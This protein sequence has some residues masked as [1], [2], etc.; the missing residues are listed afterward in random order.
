MGKIHFKVALRNLMGNK[1]SSFINIGGLAVGMAVALLIGL[2]IYDELSFNKGHSNYAR[3]GQ[4]KVHNGDGTYSS[5]PA[6]L[7][8]ELHS[9]FAGDFKNV[10]LSSNTESHII[11]A[12][13]QAGT[14]KKLTRRG[15]YMQPEGPGMFTLKMAAGTRD[16]LQNPH[17]VLLSRSLAKQLFGDED[18]VGRVANI[19]NKSAV[20]VTGVYEDLPDN[21]F[22]KEVAFVAP[23]DLYV[24]SNDF[25]RESLGDWKENAY[26]IYV[27]LQPGKDFDRVSGEIKD[28]KIPHISKE[29][30]GL[31]K[32]AFF[33]Q[34][35]SRWHLYSKYENRVTVTSEELKFV[36]FYGIIGGFVLLLAC[37]NFMNLSTARSE[38]RAKEVGIRKAIGSLRSQLIGQFF[39]E[40]LLVSVCSFL[41][42][43]GLVRLALPWFNGIAGKTL[44]IP[45][46]NPFFWFTGIA[47]ISFTGLLAGSY[48]AFY[49]SSFKAVK[50]LKGTFRLGRLAAM[51]RKMLVVLQ[52]TV[53]IALIIA[54]IVV[55]RQIQFAKDRPVGY[56]RGGLLTIPMATNDFRE[57][58]DV[59]R[60]ELKNTGVV[61][62]FAESGSPI[63]GL[64]SE[65]GGIGW[66]GKDPAMETSFGTVP[67]TVDYG[68]T[69][70]WQFKAG[71]DFLKELASDSSGFVV[72]EAAVKYIGLKDPV[73]ATLDWKKDVDHTEHYKII[74]VIKDV[75]MN[76]PFEPVTPTV[77][78]LKGGM[79]TILLRID[80]SVSAGRALSKIESVFKAIIPAVPF[81]YSFADQEYAGK[82]AAEERTGQLA[83]CFASLA[84][85]ISCLG[86][87]GMASFMAEQRVKEIGVRKVLGA[88]VFHI[89][90]ML[91]KDFVTLVTISLL[92]AA[93]VTYY[94]MHGWLQG[95]SYRTG[96]S[97]W[98]FAA[99]GTGA[100]L[101][102]LL[103]VSYQ[104]VKA[105][106]ANPVVALRSE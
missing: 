94:F 88:S 81:E 73:G 89:W 69:I 50:V 32:P 82:F 43:I 60:N 97:W 41:L 63:T 16:G 19:D 101:L 17:S 7:G 28:L 106:I 92:I 10:V 18:A 55:Y 77:F 98:I 91:S 40:S 26:A 95:Y 100:L 102:T 15:V 56:T 14:D 35:M 45:L 58:S 62:G 96:L 74:G 61:A 24:S 36:W 71:R 86:L 52:F 34:P 6:P 78:Y 39:T 38:K 37:I 80:P 1:G 67:V 2:W 12:G 64:Y 9:S 21:S 3:I 4:V 104:S 25:V 11:S 5:L 68:K 30:A 59:L 53:S 99:A 79:S 66:E 76:S 44:S 8:E 42:A 85:F 75:V 90:R 47:F 13:D 23:W 87:F 33:I 31:F 29:K 84:I 70:G 49:L 22:F 48:P 105:A 46:F 27:Q 57:K 93:P 54:T 51:P 20:K 72:N 83:G 103:T 65:T